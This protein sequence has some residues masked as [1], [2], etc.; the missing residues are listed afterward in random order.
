LLGSVL[1]YTCWSTTQDER[2]CNDGV[3]NDE[4][5]LVDA[6]DPDCQ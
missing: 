3:D 1:V 2:L 6:E 5:C 4:D